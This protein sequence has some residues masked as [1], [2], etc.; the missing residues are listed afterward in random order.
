M[1]GKRILQL[2]LALLCLGVIGFVDPFPFLIICGLLLLPLA[3]ATLVGLAYLGVAVW[4]REALH[5]HWRFLG[6]VGL[7][8][9]CVIL[10]F[11]ANRGV[12]ALA[13]AR[14][15]AYPSRVAPLLE[16]FRQTH[17]AYP[18]SLSQIASLPRPPYLLSGSDYQSSY[19]SDGPSYSYSF[20]APG[21]FASWHYNSQSS[22]WQCD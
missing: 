5:S 15:K 8:F 14:A 20:L 13:E 21:G 3:I 2:T 18:A 7:V 19:Y 12:F 11:V 6:Q 22:A 10:A 9:A 1:K 17:G 16:A 4:K